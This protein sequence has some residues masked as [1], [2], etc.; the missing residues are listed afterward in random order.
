MLVLTLYQFGKRLNYSIYK[1]YNKKYSRQVYGEINWEDP[2]KI[3][4]NIINSANKKSANS[5]LELSRDI[6]TTHNNNAL[7]DYAVILTHPNLSNY[8]FAIIVHKI[9]CGGTEFK[10]ISLISQLSLDKLTTYIN[11]APNQQPQDLA[12]TTAGLEH[13]TTSKHYACF[14]SGFH[15][16][17]EQEHRLLAPNLNWLAI[18]L[19]NYGCVGLTLSNLVKKL[20]DISDKKTAKGKWV[21]IYLNEHISTICAIKNAK[22]K[23][24]SSSDLFSLTPSMHNCGQ[25]DPQLITNLALN[26]Q[27]DQPEIGQQL[28]NSNLTNLTGGE[29]KSIEE[30]LISQKPN[31][32]LALN[33][34]INALCQ[35]ITGAGNLLQGI[36]GIIFS[37]ELGIKN[38]QLRQKIIDQLE[39]LGISISNKANLEH[40]TK[41]HKKNSLTQVFILKDDPHEAMLNQ[42]FERL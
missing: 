32:L 17:I 33:Y 30:L 41:L 38:S 3:E 42:L 16:S 13:Y 23:Y 10:E 36:D 1:L 2:E 15:H 28:L 4:W 37:G 25:L 9:A 39:W 29:A 31:T 24:C 35:I 6:L 5:K 27:I 21:I 40:Q 12:L 34:Y 19:K 22:S 26:K 7:I 14:D 18:N 20:G 8:N 11:F